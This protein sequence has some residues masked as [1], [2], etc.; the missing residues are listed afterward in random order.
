MDVKRFDAL[1][2]D[3]GS[4]PRRRVLGAL[5][6]GMLA[7]LLGL[8]GREASAQ[9]CKRSSDCPDGHG[10]FNHTCAPKCGD[11]LSCGSGTGTGCG[12]NSFCA[13]KPGGGGI[14]VK[15]ASCYTTACGKQSDCPT[16]YVC[17]A[18]CCGSND[19]KYICVLPGAS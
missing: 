11:P 7:P 6:T 12:T 2:K 15:P 8:G 18:G 9:T 13:K 5:A 1:T 14:C 17:T 3:W 16:G 4:V 10:C 19:A